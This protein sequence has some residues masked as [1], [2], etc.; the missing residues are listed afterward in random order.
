MWYATIPDDGFLSSVSSC[1]KVILDGAKFIFV[2]EFCGP[3]IIFV[4]LC[5]CEILFQGLGTKQMAVNKL[6]K[7]VT[8]LGLVYANL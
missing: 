5:W 1:G 8:A 3:I 4:K 6:I 2:P 7:A